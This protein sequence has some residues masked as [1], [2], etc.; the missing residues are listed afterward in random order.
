M[1]TSKKNGCCWVEGGV[2]DELIILSIDL[3]L[4]PW[5]I[6]EITFSQFYVTSELTS[7]AGF[8]WALS[9]CLIAHAFF[10]HLLLLWTGI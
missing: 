10:I 2:G 9:A 4:Y 5:K 1:H 3:S 7:F 8:K 6:V